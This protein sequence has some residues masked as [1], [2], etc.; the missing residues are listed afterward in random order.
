MNQLQ[1]LKDLLQ[2]KDE[3]IKSRDEI[4]RQD[5]EEIQELKYELKNIEYNNLISEVF[6]NI[7]IDKIKNF[8]TNKKIIQFEIQ[9]IKK[10]KQFQTKVSNFFIKINKENID[11]INN[12]NIG[13]VS[14]ILTQMVKAY[15]KYNN[16]KI[17]YEKFIEIKNKNFKKILS[18]GSNKINESITISSFSDFGKYNNS[19]QEE[20]KN[21][22]LKKFHQHVFKNELNFNG[23]LELLDLRQ[24]RNNFTHILKFDKAKTKNVVNKINK[25]EKFQQPHFKYILNIINKN[26]IGGN[27]IK[28]KLRKKPKNKKIRKILD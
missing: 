25:I 3:I 9:D 22:F 11:E 4:I 21:E 26:Y 7:L 1:I 10:Y 8:A 16:N 23:F 27:K 2:A 15:K 14:K 28:K 19:L 17:S 13:G 18:L 12:F 5:K 6:T 20:L 24:S